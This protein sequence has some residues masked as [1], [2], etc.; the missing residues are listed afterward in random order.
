MAMAENVKSGKIDEFKKVLRA[1]KR[2]IDIISY[3]E[4]LK[5]SLEAAKIETKRFHELEEWM[6]HKIMTTST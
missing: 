4:L 6:N 2:F 3:Q 1:D 5:L